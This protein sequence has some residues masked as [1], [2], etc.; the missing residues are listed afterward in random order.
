MLAVMFEI[1]RRIQPHPLGD[2]VNMEE[3][4]ALGDCEVGGIF[5]RDR[6]SNN[7]LDAAALARWHGDTAGSRFRSL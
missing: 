1:G 5:M 6:L 7:H 4:G 2:F 3:L